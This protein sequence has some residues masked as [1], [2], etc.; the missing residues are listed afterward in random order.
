MKTLSFFHRY[1]IANDFVFLP[2]YRWDFPE[3]ALHFVPDVEPENKKENG[4]KK[5]VN[6]LPEKTRA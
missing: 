5:H 2:D 3:P 1:L 4:Y 6:N